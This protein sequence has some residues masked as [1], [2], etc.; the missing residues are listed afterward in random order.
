MSISVMNGFNIYSVTGAGAQIDLYCIIGLMKQI[1][2][3][4]SLMLSCVSCQ[5][6]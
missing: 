4:F 1:F 3:S 5:R 2:D 6:W